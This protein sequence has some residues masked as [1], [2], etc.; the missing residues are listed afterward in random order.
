VQL[1]DLARDDAQ[2]VAALLDEALEQ[3]QPQRAAWQAELARREPRWHVLVADLLSA[4]TAPS[5]ASSTASSSARP[6]IARDAPRLET[7]ALV[8]QRLARAATAH[9]QPIEGR[10]FGPYRVLRRLGQGGMGS[11][12]L[13]ERA[14]G[15]FERQVAL[16]LVHPSLGGDA[17]RERFARERSILG[18]LDHPL[19]ARLLDAGIADDGQPYIALEYVEGVSLTE[20][21]DAQ[22]LDVRARLAL[23]LQVLEAVQHAHQNLVIHRDLKPANILVARDGQVRLLD[24][25]IAKL[26]SEGHAHETE[27]TREGGRAL[28]PDYASPEQIAGRPLGTASDVYSLGVL[29]Y[30]LVCGQR[31]YR[32]ARESRGALEDAILSVQPLEPSRQ[33]ITPEIARARGTSPTRLSHLLAGDLDTI[34]LKALKKDPAERYATADALRQDLERHLAGQ[35]VLARPDSV[36]YRV[37]TFVR[38]HRLRVGLG[39]TIGVVLVAAAV[40]SIRQAQLARTQ[41]TIARREARHAQVVQGFLLDIFKTNSVQ[42]GD[43]ARARQTT[44]RELLDVGARR[45]TDSLAGEPQAQAEV[46]HTLADMYVQLELREDAA[47][48][49]Q[50]GIAAVKQAYGGGDARVA[51][52]LLAYATDI[53]QTDRRADAE[54]ALDEARQILERIGDTTSSTRGWVSIASAHIQQYLSLAAMRRHADDA[55][56]HFRAH[57]ARWND[58]FHALQAAARARCLAGEFADAQALHRDALAEVG[59]HAGDGAAAWEITPL[60]QLAEAQMAVEPQAAEKNLRAALDVARR[61]HGDS[62]GITLQTQ[63]KL[64]ALLHG[65]GRRDEGM[66]LLDE[67]HVALGRPD[68]KATP[69]AV[70]AV[71]RFRGIALFGE[72]RIAEAEAAFATEIDE[73]RVHYPDS[74]PLSRALLLRAAALTALG[75]YDASREHLDEAWRLWRTFAGD[76]AQPAAHN[77]YRLE[78][79]RLLL[80]QGDAAGAEAE[81]R[82]VAPALHMVPLRVDETH[83]QLAL[84]QA[85][86]LQGRALEAREIAQQALDHVLASALREHQPRLEAE[87]QL[88]LGQALRQ[89]G[90]AGAARAHLERAVALRE[91]T[92]APSSPWLAEAK[93]ELTTDAVVGRGAR[94]A[95][96]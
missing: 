89:Q 47:R 82:A 8:Q 69:N 16:K 21:G 36:A 28:T 93:A 53:E 80:A 39:V 9:A 20:Y 85:R 87:A 40:V 70:W 60:V 29:L 64:G 65:T 50:Q 66:R 88:R 2:R 30:V 12:W 81:L 43:P 62:S 34:V 84:A 14:D 23:M 72:G 10:C 46:L 52:A 78:R 48:L 77:R 11:V 79:A 7:A 27:L 33:A 83:A 6:D 74:L 51:S 49:R 44:A 92:E 96:R 5:S 73:L 75:R 13:A 56:R 90:E 15:L 59:R 38:R 45:V 32:L 4:L 68:V 71:W 31:P 61:L 41:E 18:A 26:M 94:R 3:P 24:F 95:A 37:T 57:P 58:L 86:L 42:Q 55:V 17:L 54:G 19:I 91:Q 67:A 76:A 35:P 22:G 1:Q 63:V 25:G